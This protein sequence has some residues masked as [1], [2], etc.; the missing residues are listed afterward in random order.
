MGLGKNEKKEES[1]S[2]QLVPGGFAGTGPNGSFFET[3][4]WVDKVQPAL[5]VVIMKCLLLSQDKAP[6]MTSQTPAVAPPGWW[7]KLVTGYFLF[8]SP[9]LV[10]LTIALADYFLFP[11]DYEAAKDLTNLN[12]VFQRSGVYIHN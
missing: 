1:P 3:P 7:V 2:C 9:N 6:G 11:Y 4:G 10:W 12:W 8:F 5:F